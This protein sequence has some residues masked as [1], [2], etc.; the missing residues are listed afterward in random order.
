MAMAR[1]VSGKMQ[2]IATGVAETDKL[3]GA[4]ATAMEEQ[5]GD[6]RRHRRMSASSP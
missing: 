1:E 6:G 4:I 5:Q 3:I 2:E